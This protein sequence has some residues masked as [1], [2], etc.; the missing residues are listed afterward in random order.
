MV[1][2][3]AGEAGTGPVQLLTCQEVGPRDPSSGL[4]LV[5]FAFHSRK[6]CMELGLGPGP[7]PSS[8]AP[9]DLIAGRSAAA[10]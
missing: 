7:R 10:G 2:G 9:P 1:G 4:F 3:E 8:T 6:R 5:G